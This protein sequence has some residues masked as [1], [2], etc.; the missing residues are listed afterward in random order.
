[1]GWR[2]VYIEDALRLNYKLN[3]IGI[4]T[5]NDLIWINLDEIDVIVIESLICNTSVKLLIEIVKKGISVILCGDNHMPIGMIN[6]LVDNQRS[7]KFNRKQIEWNKSL[8]QIVWQR[9]IKHKI[10]LQLIVLY[11]LGKKEKL[12]LLK[13][14][15]DNV[16]VGD[17]TNRE[18]HAAKIYFHE[19]FGSDFIR[20]RNSTDIY[21]SSINF[22]Y[23]VIRSKISQEIVS[24][25]YISS[26]GIF[27][28]NEFNY[29]GLAD[30][31]IEVYRPIIDYYV[32]KLIREENVTFLTSNI[33]EKMLKILFNYV[34]F[35]KSKQKILES[36]RLYVISVT[37]SLTN[38]NLD[39]LTFP[40][41]YE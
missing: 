15:A 3:S 30:D 2:I 37:D 40:T 38:E 9:I 19:L 13:E 31:L 25:G 17:I 8:K 24:H 28:C 27:H 36:I 39:D 33:K 22:M 1:M 6:S 35:G 29:F 26:L 41:F 12:E 20:E 11:K 16:E 5:N 34:N 32:Y 14:F 10:L 23:Q 18:G 21:N 4:N 7:A